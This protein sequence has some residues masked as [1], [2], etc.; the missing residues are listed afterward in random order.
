[1]PAASIP[2]GSQH[3]KLIVDDQPVEIEWFLILGR[4]EAGNSPCAERDT[5]RHRRVGFN[6]WAVRKGPPRHPAGCTE[7]SCRFY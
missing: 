3:H 7:G 2:Q 6:T 4:S 1:M 5:S